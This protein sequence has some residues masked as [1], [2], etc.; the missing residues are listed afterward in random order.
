M[1]LLGKMTAFVKVVET[2]SF[3]EAGRILHISPTM[4]SRHIRELEDHI[5]ARLLNRTTRH[6]SLTEIGDLFHGRCVPLLADVAELEA[7]VTALHVV[8][9]GLLR[10]SAPPALGATRIA[11]AMAEFSNNYPELSTELILTERTVDLVEEGFD[12]A[13]HLGDL[14][15][16]GCLTRLLTTV[17]TVSCSAPSYLASHGTPTCPADLSNHNCSFRN[18]QKSSEEW[19][20]VDSVGKNH[21]VTITGNFRTNSPMAQLSAALS[22]HIVA[23]LPI[24]LVYEHIEAGRLVNLFPDFRGPEIPVRLV[25]SPGRHIAAKIRVFV[26]FLIE[27]AADWQSMIPAASNS[28]DESRSHR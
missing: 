15:D 18:V 19:K 28:S 12:V 8:P 2:N 6:V 22:G 17:P 10:V 14:P 24:L 4:V 11:P 27:K 1:D 25:Y 5:G 26:D 23:L 3:T 9:S 20:F 7:S 16:S 13:V 21:I